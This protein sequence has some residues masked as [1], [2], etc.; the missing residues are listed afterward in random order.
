MAAAELKEIMPLEKW[1]EDL[2]MDAYR[3]QVDTLI[4]SQHQDGLWHTLIDHEDAYVEVSGSAGFAYGILKGIRTGQLP[5]SYKENAKKAVKGICGYI[6]QDGIVTQVSY[7]TVVADTL[8]YYK[9]VRLRSTGYGQ[10]IVLMMLV[11]LMY[12]E[13]QGLML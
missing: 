7:G 5:A 2:I 8:A 3:R 4:K 10:N 13:K 6:D 12:W 9:N 1:V 11:E